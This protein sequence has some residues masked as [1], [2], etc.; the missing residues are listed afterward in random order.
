VGGRDAFFQAAPRKRSGTRT[1]HPVRAAAPTITCHFRAEMEEEVLL[2]RVTTIEVDVSREIIGGFQH[3]AAA[4]ASSEVDPSRQLL[5]HVVP[6]RNFETVN[7]EG[8]LVIDPP[9]PQNPKTFYF[10]VRATHDEDGEGEL[11]VIARQGQVP[12]VRLTL[13]PRIVT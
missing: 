8:P 7:E 12:L 4:E 3:V 13:R 11:W 6:K 5:I 9:E 10:D 1:P 2:N